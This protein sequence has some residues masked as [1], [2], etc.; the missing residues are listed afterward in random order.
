LLA[1]SLM[2]A[3]LCSGFDERECCTMLEQSITLFRGLG[4]KNDLL[5]S[6][7]MGATILRIDWSPDQKKSIMDEIVMLAVESSRESLIPICEEA[8][9]FAGEKT[10]KRDRSDIG[11]IGNHTDRE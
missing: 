9:G 3:S 5:E 6:L 2:A 4:R 7:M 8:L 1:E 11:K 10:R